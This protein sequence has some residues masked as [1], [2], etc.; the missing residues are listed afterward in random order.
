M[1]LTFLLPRRKRGTV[2]KS[3]L[4]ITIGERDR[5]VDA[6]SRLLSQLA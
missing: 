5:V 1:G 3:K 2:Q 6:E 4:K